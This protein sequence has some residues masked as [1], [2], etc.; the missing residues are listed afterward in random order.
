[1]E[2]VNTGWRQMVPAGVP[3]APQ[4][5]DAD[6]KEL[7]TAARLGVQALKLK[8]AVRYVLDQL[9]GCYAGEPLVGRILVWPSNELLA[10]RTGL[11]ERTIR[12]CLATLL[13]LGVVGA[14]DSANG[15]R[16]AIRS[17]AGQIMD[18]YGFDLSPL[19]ARAAEFADEVERQKG[20]RELRGR[21]HDQITICRRSTQEALKELGEWFP[22]TARDDLEREFEQLAAL[23][24]RR[25]AAQAPDAALAAWRDLR[26]RSEDRYYAACGG[27]NGRHI[28]DNNDSLDQSCNKRP[29]VNERPA[30]TL[31]LTDLVA[32]CPDAFGYADEVET[33]ADLVG[34]A[35][36]LRGTIGAHESAW[37]EAVDKLGPIVA[38]AAFFVVLQAYDRDQSVGQRKIKNAG[39]YF[40]SYVRMIAGGQIDLLEEIR[41][42]R[43]RR[44]H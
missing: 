36:R 2:R 6:K 18:A 32:A 26:Q 20:Q 43:R 21:M 8:P 40:R 16:F 33:M 34:A 25:T 38:A 10:A 42:L 3:L 14:K 9:V 35:A 31:R 1:M 11:A 13:Q 30:E 37:Q 23:T 17:K 44:A 4:Y 5:H 24:P 41:A 15:K 29:G 27:K 19:L 12:Y 39:G 28:E 7:F 22:K